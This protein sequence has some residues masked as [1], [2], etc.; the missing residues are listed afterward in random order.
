MTKQALRTD[1]FRAPAHLACAL[2][3][4]DTSG[5]EPHEERELRWL[6]AW[7]RWNYGPRVSVVDC[8]EPE[9]CR[10]MSPSIRVPMASLSGVMSLWL[11]GDATEYTVLY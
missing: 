8:G 1:I 3:N 10:D 2:I 9:F 6:E 11:A 4:G 7:M 5:L